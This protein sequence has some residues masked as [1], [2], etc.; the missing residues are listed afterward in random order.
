MGNFCCVA[1]LNETKNK[2]TSE[3]KSTF[4]SENNEKDKLE[5]EL[6]LNQMENR[7][8]EKE[9]VLIERENNLSKREQQL[10]N[11]ESEYISQIQ[12]Q[13]QEIL[14]FKKN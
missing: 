7:L 4:F 3:E 13:K 12:K 11:K 9:Q 5:K 10:N 6:D 14:S 2:E 1:G 8:M